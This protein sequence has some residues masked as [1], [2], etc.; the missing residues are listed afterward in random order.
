VTFLLWPVKSSLLRYVSAL[1]DG[2]LSVEDGA[3]ADPEAGVFAFPGDPED[4]SG[5]RF[6]GDLRLRAHGGMLFVRVARPALETVDGGGL[7]LTV[8]APGEGETE[9]RLVLAH[10]AERAR[11]DGAV[12]YDARLSEPGAAL[13]GG[14]Y[15]PGEELDPL[16][17]RQD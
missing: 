10:L 14:Y 8:L 7:A 15:R 16:E 6:R 2:A 9:E 12:L 11:T 13:F 1:P 17:V 4:P 3:E 5:R